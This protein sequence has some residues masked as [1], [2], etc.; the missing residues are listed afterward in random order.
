[1]IA[2]TATPED[3]K[4]AQEV[5]REQNSAAQG[6][7]YFEAPEERRWKGWCAEIVVL[8]WLEGLLNRPGTWVRSTSEVDIIFFGHTIDVKTSSRTRPPHEGYNVSIQDSQ[9]RPPVAEHYFFTICDPTG[10]R[11]WLCGGITS[12]LFMRVARAYKAGERVRDLFNA[13]G[14]LHNILINQLQLPV[15]WAAGLA[16]ATHV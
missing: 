7:H 8:R 16:R 14:D 12:A 1:V 3:Q 6:R 15:D 2:L 11:Y 10:T 13:S 9:L 5:C 4:L